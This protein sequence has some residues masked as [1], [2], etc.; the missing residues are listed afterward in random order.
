MTRVAIIGF[1][2]MGTTHAQAYEAV[3]GAEVAAVVARDA[4]RAAA[5]L[6]RLGLKK[7]VYPTLEQLLSS[8]EVHAVDICTP[9]DLHVPFALEAISAGKHVFCEKPLAL[10]PEEAGKICT[11][12]A[13]AGI[14]AQVG[15]CIRFW[16]EYLALAGLVQ[17]GS[18]GRLL[19]LHLDRRAA[20]PPHGTAN[21]LNVSARSG[22]AA[23]DLHI[24]DTD[25]V[26]SLF[27]MPEAVTSTGTKDAY[28]WSQ[29]H[30]IYH[31]DGLSVSACGGW[32]SPG[33]WDFKMAFQAVFEKAVVEYDR[34]RNPT[35]LI[36]REGVST[37]P[38]PCGSPFSGESISGLGNISSLGGYYNQS[39]YFIECIRN[40]RHP[41]IAT[42]DQAREAVKVVC[43]EVASAASNRTVALTDQKS[44]H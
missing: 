20:R 42:L 17:S 37:T 40:A 7:P 38:L 26:L 22:G 1:S 36:T 31:F 33:K 41:E 5:N 28:G 24:H 2:F 39:A 11:A 9:T 35:L 14:F 30:T 13:A 23:M 15:H 27:G 19:S 43:T 12:A 8:E 6:E 10:D 44:T 4:G 3:A 29:I 32:N 16:P 18:V 25:F 21:W 34:R